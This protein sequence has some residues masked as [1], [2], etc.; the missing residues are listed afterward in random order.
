VALDVAEAA[1]APQEKRDLFHAWL[2][3]SFQDF[4]AWKFSWFS[5]MG[6]W[7]G[8]IPDSGDWRREK[9]MND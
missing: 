3:I 1:K 2:W 4:E 5:R 8:I 7:R 6:C 9:E